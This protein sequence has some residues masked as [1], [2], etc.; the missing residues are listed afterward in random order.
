MKMGLLWKRFLFT[1]MAVIVLLVG[2][3]EAAKLPG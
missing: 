3:G 1:S 2:V